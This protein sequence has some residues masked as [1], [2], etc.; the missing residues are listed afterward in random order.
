MATLAAYKSVVLANV[1]AIDLSDQ[2]MKV[3][4]CYVSD[5][6]GGL[7]A[8]GGQN[9]YGAGGYLQTPLEET[10]PVDSRIKDQKRLPSL[11]MVYVIDRSGSMEMIENGNSVTNLELAKEAARRSLQFLF[12]RDRAGVLSFDSDP[13]WLVPIQQVNDRTSMERDIGTLRPGGGTD[14][15]AAVKEIYKAVPPDPSTLKHVV[16]LTDGGADPT[17]IVDLVKQMHDQNGVPFTSIGIGSEVP[18]FMADIATAGHVFY[19]KAT[20]AAARRRFLPADTVLTTRSYIIEQEFTPALSANS[21]IMQGLAD[22][23]GNIRLPSLKGYIATTPKDTA[24]VILTAPGY[25][26][27]LLAAWQY[28]LGRAV[29][30]T[31]DATAR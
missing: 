24:T 6:G 18:S 26:D 4:Q 19:Y 28:G 3:L 11:L 14:I 27:P 31:S 23:Q 2:R 1:S 29:A 17:G 30:W 21:Q 20:G 15:L 16:L 10:L 25:N 9:S 22:S 8:I 12:P 7:V 13:Q 5:L